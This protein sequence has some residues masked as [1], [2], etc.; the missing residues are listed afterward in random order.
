[1]VSSWPVFP[2]SRPVAWLSPVCTV[3]LPPAEHVP[4]DSGAAAAALVEE[5][6]D[7]VQDTAVVVLLDG[8]I[9]RL[10]LIRVA[11]I[12]GHCAEQE[13]Q[14]RVDGIAGGTGI[15]PE[16]AAD[17]VDGLAAESLLQHFEERHGDLV[18]SRNHESP[19][20]GRQWLAFL[21]SA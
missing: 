1:M 11:R 5:A 3:L 20:T 21:C 6:R 13:R 10:R 19:V 12:P 8:L 16:L 9:E 7:I 18:S 14:R 4:E 2:A 15:G 17:G